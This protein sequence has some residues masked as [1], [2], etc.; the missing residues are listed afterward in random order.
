MSSCTCYSAKRTS[1][2]GGG[3]TPT[4]PCENCLIAGHYILSGKDSP[5]PCGEDFT[6]DLA[7]GIQKSG[8]DCG[9]SFK[10]THSDS[11]LTSVSV[12]SEGMLSATTSVDGYPSTPL[13][14]EWKVSCDCE[15]SVLSSTGTLQVI[16][17]KLCSNVDLGESKACDPCSGKI[18][19]ARPLAANCTSLNVTT[20]GGSDVYNLAN[21]I[22]A[23]ACSGSPLAFD[24]V[25]YP[26]GK[27]ESIAIDGSGVL[28]FTVKSGLPAET[29]IVKYQAVCKGL[30][31]VGEAHICVKS[32][33]AGK[34]CPDGQSCDECTGGCVEQTS[35]LKIGSSTSDSGSSLNVK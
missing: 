17:R 32:K 25:N 34:S 26:Q 6:V 22:D 8:C 33:C 30:K 35:D 14:V 9:L 15:G 24:L 18:L 13:M 20:C 3:T 10:V 28:R 31:V 1:P 4:G 19:Y 2:P 23:E 21:Q 11:R 29:L 12:D 27:F 5:L 7:K 16:P